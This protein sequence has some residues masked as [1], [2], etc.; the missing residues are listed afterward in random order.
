M[1]NEVD[2]LR[3]LFKVCKNIWIDELRAHAVRANAALRPELAEEPTVSGEAVALGELTLREVD[4][5]MAALPDEQRTVLS[6]VAVEGLS[7]RE[8]AEVL[9]TPIGTVMSRLARARAALAAQFA[10]AAADNRRDGRAPM[11][12]EPRSVSD[13]EALSALLDGELGAD[14]AQR[15]RQRLARDPALAE[16]LAVLQMTNSTVR[17]AYTPVADEPLPERLVDLTAR[18]RTGAT[19][20]ETTSCPW[21]RARRAESSPCRRRSPRASRSRWGSCSASR[22]G[23]ACFRPMRRAGP[24]TRASS[25]PAR[26]CSMPSQTLPSGESRDLGAGLVATARL[27]FATAGGGYCR[28][29]DLVG[30]RGATAALACG[31]ADGWRVE[32]ATFAPAGAAGDYRPASGPNPVLDAAIDERIEGAPLGADAERELIERGWVGVPHDN[33]EHGFTQPRSGV[34]SRLVPR[35]CSRAPLCRPAGSRCDGRAPR[36]SASAGRS[37]SSCPLVQILRDVVYE[38]LARRLNAVE[39]EQALVARPDTPSNS[40]RGDDPLAVDR[41]RSRLGRS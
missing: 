16:R 34:G 13:D 33:R 23:R 32:T 20:S 29:I 15:L 8:A 5:A 41:R 12:N 6:L 26:R 22:S 24:Q 17:A 25:R 28:H 30:P 19:G 14:E 36:G 11:S 37:G 27:T 40:L 4:R 9:D 18:R 21:A 7:Y 10:V 2:V 31:G 3:W 38:P 39:L 35:A 1:P